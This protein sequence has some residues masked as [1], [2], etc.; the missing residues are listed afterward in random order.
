MKLNR[1]LGP[2]L[3]VIIAVLGVSDLTLAQTPEKESRPAEQRAASEASAP[4][5]ESSVTY[6]TIRIGA[7]LIPYK[8]A[9]AYAASFNNYV[10][11]ELKFGL[12]KS[13]NI[14]NREANQNWDWKRQTAGGQG[15]SGF[16]GSPNVEPDLVDA[17]ASNVHLQVQ[18]ENGIYDLATP[19][20]QVEHTV[21]H[22]EMP[23]KLRDRIT[24]NYYD[25]GHMMY[26]REDDLSKLKR[27]VGGFIDKVSK[28]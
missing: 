15:R 7:Q 14:R 27:N 1:I 16:P 25:S 11:E 6:H 17:L 13:Y 5:E 21:S 2:Y 26:L 18:I 8:A 20:F 12:E 4:K 10:R 22:L 19:F 24:M 9:G 28:R 3:T 23:Q